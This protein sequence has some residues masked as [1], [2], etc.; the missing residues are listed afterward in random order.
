MAGGSRK[1]RRIPKNLPLR[2]SLEETL[3]VP[4][5]SDPSDPRL[6]CPGHPPLPLGSQ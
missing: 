3:H 2:F 1:H 6:G 5:P 4:P